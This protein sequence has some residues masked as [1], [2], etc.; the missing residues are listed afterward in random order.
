MSTRMAIMNHGYIEQIGTPTEI[1]EFPQNRFTANFIGNTNMFTAAITEAED[2]H[3]RFKSSEINCDFYAERPIDGLVGQTVY[4]AIRPE[5]IQIE[6]FRANLH[7][8]ISKP[9]NTLY[10]IIKDIA[11][12]GGLS[13]Y[14]VLLDNGQRM[15]ATDFNIER[16]ADHPTWEDRVVLT[17][18]SANMMVLLS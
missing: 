11:Y 4:L 7:T 9:F 8:P 14:H 6:K 3:T 5:K 12:H 18:D 13:T 1:Y 10:G 2:S 16:D 17:F 15:T